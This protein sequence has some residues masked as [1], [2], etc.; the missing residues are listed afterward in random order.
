V[1]IFQ[2][3]KQNDIVVDVLINN[4]GIGNWSWFEEQEISF[5]KKQIDLNITSTVSL[6]RLFLDQVSKKN[7]SYLLNVGSLGGRF[8]IPKKQVYGATKSFIS[9]FTKCLQL[10]QAGSN[11]RISL[12]SP[13]GINTKPELLVLNHSMKGISQATIMEPEEVAKQA[14]DGLFRGKKEIIPDTINRLLAVLDK[15]IPFFIQEW[16]I[17]RKL[18]MIGKKSVS[19]V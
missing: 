9:Y 14:I 13:G 17:R 11:V 18:K 19:K 16:I 4:S 8:I 5:Y 7:T 2:Q 6:T 1:E 15:I 12:L 10:E 3:L